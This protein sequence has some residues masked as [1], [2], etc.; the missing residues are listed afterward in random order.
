MIGRSRLDGLH[1]VF[2]AR[3]IDTLRDVTGSEYRRIIGLHVTIDQD[4]VIGLDAGALD[5]LD[6]RFNAGR[7]Y[8]QIG[9]DRRA[10]IQHHAQRRAVL[11]DSV[12]LGRGMHGHAVLLAPVLDHAAGGVVHHA[13]HHA[14]FH[15]DHGQ[16]R[17]AL[18]QRLEND[19]ADETRAHQHHTGAGLGGAGDTARVGQGPA[20]GYTRQINAGYRRCRRPRAGGDQERVVGQLTATLQRHL[21]RRAV[22]ACDA[23]AQDVDVAL[24]KVI[25]SLAQMCACLADLFGQEIRDGHARIRRLG[26]ITDH[27]HRC[28]GLKFAQR[29][30]R[31]HTRW[32]CAYHYVL[33]DEVYSNSRSLAAVLRRRDASWSRRSVG[34]RSTSHGLRNSAAASRAGD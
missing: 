15:L 30:G 14:A 10:G 22:D 29:L 9:I 23:L 4:A 27:G 7:G 26:F 16:S 13:R 25:A 2:P 34:H 18:G 32:P 3:E 20:R 21:S 11:L 17:A 6:V 1:R 19:A 12:D 31:D 33:H 8:H 24:G 5:Q 28:A